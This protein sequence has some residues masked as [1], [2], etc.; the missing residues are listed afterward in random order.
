MTKLNNL[1]FFMEPELEVDIHYLLPEEGGRRHG[2][3]SGYRGQFYY[4][5][6]DW[7]AVQTLLDRDICHPGETARVHLNML[8]PHCHIGMFHTRQE[9]DI[10]E[11][12]QTVAKGIIR[13]ILRP[14]F[15]CKINWEELKG[16]VY[17]EDGSLR[18]IYVL[19]TTAE[20]WMKWTDWIRRSSYRFEWYDPAVE[21]FV[22]YID[23]RP[24]WIG[25]VAEPLRHAP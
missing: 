3:V 16:Q 19:S 17:Y 24:Y 14:D 11:G 21:Q 4:Y 5:G 10:R 20:D 25:G 22:D 12:P 8:S 23:F 13:T 2:I 1:L 15:E 9:F 6:H 7:D 18:D